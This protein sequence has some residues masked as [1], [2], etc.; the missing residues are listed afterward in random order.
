MKDRDGSNPARTDSMEIHRGKVVEVYADPPLNLE[1]DGE[2]PGL[3]TPFTAR[4]LEG[5]ARFVVSDAAIKE[6]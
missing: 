3:T 2:L 1:Y 6:L 4:V 5:A